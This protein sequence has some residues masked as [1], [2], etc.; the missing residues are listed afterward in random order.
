MPQHDNY[1]VSL[2]QPQYV[3]YNSVLN[4]SVCTTAMAQYG[5]ADLCQTPLNSSSIRSGSQVFLLFSLPSILSFCK[6][7]PEPKKVYA[8]AALIWANKNFYFQMEQLASSLNGLQINGNFTLFSKKQWVYTGFTFVWNKG[9]CWQG[10][11]KKDSAV[12]GWL[13]SLLP[14]K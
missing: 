5:W 14:M 2:A 1:F 12:K 8:E 11:I 9:G 3:L 10:L 4:N 6:Q 7:C 13:K